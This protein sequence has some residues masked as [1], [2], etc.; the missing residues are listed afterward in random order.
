M[1][2]GIIDA[3]DTAKGTGSVTFVGSGSG[4]KPFLESDVADGIVFAEL[5]GKRVHFQNRISRDRRKRFLHHA[6]IME[7]L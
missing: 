1:H 2:E 5:R 7:V 6:R 3:I 4:S